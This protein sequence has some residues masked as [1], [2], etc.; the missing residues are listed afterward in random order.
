MKKLL[1][2]FVLVFLCFFSF[3]FLIASKTDDIAEYEIK[4]FCQLVVNAT[5]SNYTMEG[6][7]SSNEDTISI[8]MLQAS[9]IA[10][11]IVSEM[12]EVFFLIEDGTYQ[13]NDNLYQSRLKEMNDQ[14]G[15]I[16]TIPLGSFL[17][18]AFFMNIG[19]SI[20]LKYITMTYLTSEVIKE[21]ESYGINH[22][23]I[24]IILKVTIHLKV[25][26][27][28]IMDEFTKVI[29]YP[30]VME[31]IQGEIPQWYQN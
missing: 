26:T 6:I 7:V 11:Q 23:M 3:S 28:S 21:V 25:A 29:E 14:G 31:I 27:L 19:P 30:L 17:D 22:M 18:N 1:F 8:D 20:H 16:A 13:K 5:A 9:N 2:C 12:E 4:R 24:V 15:V 10:S